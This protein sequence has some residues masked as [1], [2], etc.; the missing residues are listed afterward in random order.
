MKPRNKQQNLKKL[1][2]N[3]K[4]LGR[5][6][7]DS[8]AKLKTVLRQNPIAQRFGLTNRNHEQL[9]KWA[10]DLKSGSTESLRKEIGSI[11]AELRKLAKTEDPVKKAAL[12]Q[13]LRKRL[14]DLADLSRDHVGSKSAQAALKRAI[15]QLQLSNNDGLSTDA[16]EALSE[17][18][19][20]TQLEFEEIAQSVR[21]LK[22]LETALKT[23][24]MAK[25]LNN[26]EMLD[27]KACAQ[28]NSLADYEALYQKMLARS[29]GGMGQGNR[30]GNGGRGGAFGGPGIG[31]GGK[32]PEDDAAKTAFKTERSRS[33]ITAGKILLTLKTKGQGDRGQ[34]RK[35]YREAIRA[36]KQGL[37]EAI[38][39]EQIPP[40]YR[41]G[42]QKYFDDLRDAPPKKPD[43]K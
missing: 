11:Q 3:Q 21:D 37:S 23:L 32:A 38:Q 41:K 17:S 2:A 1:S 9:K 6:Y 22:E 8:V 43:G 31:R 26:G 10:R 40:G 13:R 19:D 18:L 29:G 15:E 35:Q 7:R 34:A 16:L 36:L 30:P 5:R 28:C 33:A 4:A 42:I 14:Q 24:A 27:G 20:L 12:R 39:A 25:R